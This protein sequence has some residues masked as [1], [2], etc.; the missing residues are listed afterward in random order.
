MSTSCFLLVWK[1]REEAATSSEDNLDGVVNSG[2]LA[3]T[4]IRF[5]DGWL[6]LWLVVMVIGFF[7]ERRWKE[8]ER[9]KK[10]RKRSNNRKLIRI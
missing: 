3:A 5:C 4:S 1:S 7:W 2:V 8:E 9:K 10:E 6:E